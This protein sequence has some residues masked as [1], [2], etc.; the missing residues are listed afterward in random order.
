[1]AYEYFHDGKKIE[2]S[3][4][5]G[6]FRASLPW[7]NGLGDDQL[8][9]FGITKKATVERQPVPSHDKRYEIASPLDDG[10]WVIVPREVSETTVETTQALI[11]A[12]ATEI[13][14][15]ALGTDRTL[16]A[17]KQIKQTLGYQ[18]FANLP[19]TYVQWIEVEA[20]ASGV[21]AEQLHA[22]WSQKSATLVEAA[23]A[24]DAIA[25][26]EKAAIAAKFAEGDATGKDLFDIADAADFSPVLAILDA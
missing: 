10:G 19:A 23:L 15:Q 12:K 11:D 7:L 9:V 2:E 16:D 24:L 22:V 1:M 13:R 26:R 17:V 25:I 8:A 3:Q 4:I 14:N 5:I 6:D 18:P 20:E 21:T